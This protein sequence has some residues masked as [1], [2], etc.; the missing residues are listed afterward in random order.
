MLFHHCLSVFKVMSV[1]PIDRYQN[2]IAR[3]MSLLDLKVQLQKRFRLM[4]HDSIGHLKMLFISVL[5]LH[6]GR[7]AGALNFFG[8][9]VPRGFPK[10]GS[11]VWVF[12]EKLRVLGAKILKFC[13]LRAEI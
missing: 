2:P 7:G 10:V 13:I 4:A 8:G 11:S 12:L 3:V 6:S 5:S 1:Y 9:Y